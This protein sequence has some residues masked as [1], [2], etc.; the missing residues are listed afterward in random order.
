MLTPVAQ[1][2]GVRI[3]PCAFGKDCADG[4]LLRR[5]GDIPSTVDTL[6]IGSG[7]HAFAPL[8]ASESLRGRRTVVVWRAGGIARSLRAAA[9]RV[10]ELHDLAVVGASVHVPG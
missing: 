5:A 9:H 1:D 4:A 3:H 7:D 6:V 2:A 8:V 10:V